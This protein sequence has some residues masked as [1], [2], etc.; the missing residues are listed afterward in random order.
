MAFQPHG[1][2]RIEVE[3]PLL[4]SHAR[5]PWNRELVVQWR[6]QALPYAIEMQR[7]G[8]WIGVG[9]MRGSMTCTLDALEL[10]RETAQYMIEH[11]G[12]IG[13]AH[14]AGPDVE[15]YAMMRGVFDRMFE[16]L[17]PHAH[18]HRLDEVMPWA[19]VCLHL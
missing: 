12:A 8:P 15:G 18:F 17:C 4:I 13:S 10:H 6:R 1:E 5:G 19:R 16:G 14:V 3:Y 11:L 9:V 2:L 7:L